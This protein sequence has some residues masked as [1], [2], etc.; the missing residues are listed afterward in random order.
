MADQSGD[1]LNKGVAERALFPARGLPGG[2]QLEIRMEISANH[3]DP[4]IRRVAR[5]VKPYNL[6]S[7]Y[8]EW[9]AMAAK[10]EELAAGFVNEARNI[11]AHEFYLR[12]ADFY[13]RALVY[14]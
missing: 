7:W 4:D 14:L 12:A 3:P 11:T 13:R 9:S 1:V 5:S 8:S 2:G 10:N 6:E